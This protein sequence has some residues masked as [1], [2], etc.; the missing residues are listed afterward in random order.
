MHRHTPQHRH[1]VALANASAA[2]S[3]YNL[4]LAE[5]N[6][7]KGSNASLLASDNVIKKRES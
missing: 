3:A 5:A 2:T 6:V 4:A 7:A 1:S